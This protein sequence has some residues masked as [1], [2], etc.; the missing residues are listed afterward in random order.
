MKIIEKYTGE[1]VYM[2]P[3][4]AIGDR[5]AVLKNTPAALI[6]THIVETDENCEVM[7]A[8]Q[9][10]SALRS[11]YNIDKNLTEDEAIAAIQELVNAPAPEPDTSPTAE[12]RIAAALEYQVMAALPD[13]EMV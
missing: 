7:W 6:F 9:N 5:E 11:M 2:F 13:N 10:L 12:E 4:G 1:K 3:N 8:L